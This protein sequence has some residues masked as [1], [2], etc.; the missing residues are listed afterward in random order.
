MGLRY[1]RIG[2]RV[3]P[4]ADVR[5]IGYDVATG[6]EVLAAGVRLGAAE[7]GLLAT[8]GQATIPVVRQPARGRAVDG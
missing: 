6:E 2:R 5:P 8:V 4:G 1:V 3:K 7:L